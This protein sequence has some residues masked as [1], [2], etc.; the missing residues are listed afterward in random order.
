MKKFIAT[1]VLLVCLTLVPANLTLAELDVNLISVSIDQFTLIEV[2]VHHD[3]DG[4]QET[5]Q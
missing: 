3:G 5:D 2:N 1:W 4:Q